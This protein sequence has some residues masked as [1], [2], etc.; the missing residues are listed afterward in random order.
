MSSFS[1]HLEA[2]ATL[3]QE[4]YLLSVF[5]QVAALVFAVPLFSCIPRTARRLLASVV[6]LLAF[7]PASEAFPQ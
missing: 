7:Q 3:Q 2:D 5:G 6:S 4:A 1:A